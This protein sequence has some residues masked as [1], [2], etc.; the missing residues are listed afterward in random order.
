MGKGDKKSKRGKITI[1]SYGVRRR[2]KSADKGLEAR[3]GSK[4]ETVKP[5]TEKPK[6][7]KAEK[8]VAPAKKTAAEKKAPAE[9]KAS[10]EKK[11]KTSKKES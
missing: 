8:P 4:V 2:S 10:T 5:K 6:A 3:M 11:P 9:K 1:G 7:P